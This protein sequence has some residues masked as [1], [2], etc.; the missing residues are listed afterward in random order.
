MR[1]QLEETGRVFT[2]VEPPLGTGGEAATH[3]VAESADFAA[4]IF[5]RPTPEREAKLAAMLAT[6][7]DDPTAGAGQPSFA[8]PVGRLLSV[9]GGVAFVGY[10]MSRVHHARLIHEFYN[11]GARLRLCPLFH[12]GYLMRTARNL[13]VTV[14]SLHDCG[15][16]VGDLSAANLLVSARALVTLV[17][18]DSC[19][20][21]AAGRVF[22]CP[23]GTPEYTPPE[24][25]GA[26]FA[27]VDRGPEHD[28]FAL[29]VLVFQLLMQGLHPFA[30]VYTGRGEPTSVPA[31]IAAGHWPYASRPTPFRPSP[32][33]PPWEI[34]PPAVGELFRLCFEEGHA[35]PPRRPTARAWQRALREAEQQLRTCPANPQHRFYQELAEC[36]WCTIA[37]QQG[38]DPFP[39]C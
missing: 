9:D 19:Q 20:V 7:P 15:Y 18:T 8:W 11:P 29:A 35:D 14:R 33:A 25:Q 2:L 12:Y 24:L 32:H 23:V 38:R 30:G 17:D 6:P 4:K 34:L 13:A 16:V 5:H 22:R 1:V 3:A 37:V 21:P 31:R 36:P 27:D 28:A 26:R 10:L 39:P